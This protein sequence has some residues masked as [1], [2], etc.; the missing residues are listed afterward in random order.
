[1]TEAHG[2]S[3]LAIDGEF[4]ASSRPASR[5]ADALPCPESLAYVIYTSGSTGTPKSVA[6]SRGALAR[7]VAAAADVYGTR[8]GDR[9][10]QFASLSFDTSIE[11]IFVALTRGACVVVRDD[12]M[13]ATPSDFARAC[14]ESSITVLD[15]PTAFW[16]ELARSPDF[17]LP[18][19]VRVV[20]LGGEAAQPD[21]AAMWYA[22]SPATARLLNSYGPT[23]ATVI[24]TA[25]EIDRTDAMS[26]KAPIGT[27]LPC[28]GAYVLDGSLQ[29]VPDRLQGELV[30]GGET[31][32]RGYLGDP[33]ATAERFVPD[34][35]SPVAGARMY[36]TGDVAIRGADGRL[37]YR[38]RV[39]R[40]VK[41]RGFRVDLGEVE[42]VLAEHADVREAAA[43][44]VEREHAKSLVAYVLASGPN[45]SVD[46]LFAHLRTR[47]PAYMIPSIIVPV[48]SWP[49]T[50]QHKVDYRALSRIN[51]PAPSPT[52]D[53]APQTPIEQALAA[54]WCGLL[55][56]ENVSIHDNFFE[57][58]GDSILSIQM[59]AGAR[60]LGIQLGP[61]QVFEHPTIA[62]LAANA[63]AAE[64]TREERASSIMEGVDADAL[65][66]ALATVEFE[67]D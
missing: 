21:R 14:V 54:L 6:V 49:L 31:L 27:P 13:I 45:L 35:I 29:P 26:G 1:M 65:S 59:T 17:V 30:L 24:A 11:E 40:Q 22:K 37:E 47:L 3:V 25:C 48:E 62:A 32:A 63:S 58:G 50:V 12:A 57:L 52:A 34:P 60:R 43:M 61:L 67:G 38:G 42:S 9:V 8:P 10:M 36:R 18:P 20:I 66:S 64:P 16:H 28:V 39:D 56:R 15:L 4:G 5:L 41:V 53:A 23:E 51:L 33:S 2:V 44:V 55:G 7:F 19:S 46:A